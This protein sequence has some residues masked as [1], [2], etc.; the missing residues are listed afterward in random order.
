MSPGKGRPPSDDPKILNTRV[1]LSETDLEKLDYCCEVLS[2][3]K[4]EVIRRGIEKV[5][6]EAQKKGK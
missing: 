6:K 5:Y 3:T 2:L 4:A 1:R